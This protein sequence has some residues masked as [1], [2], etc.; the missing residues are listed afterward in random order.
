MF[1]FLSCMRAELSQSWPT[2]CNPLGCS[3]PVSS[4][5]GTVPARILKWV[6][7]GGSHAENWR[8]PDGRACI[9]TRSL[10]A[11]WRTLHEKATEEARRNHEFGVASRI[12]T[13][14]PDNLGLKTRLLYL[15]LGRQS[16]DKWQECQGEPCESNSELSKDERCCLGR[17]WHPRH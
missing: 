15:S 1:T 16:T 13:L 11:G 7:T 9:F 2:L 8:K 10:G 4:V 5:H 14:E 6:A 3:L 17:E 12:Q